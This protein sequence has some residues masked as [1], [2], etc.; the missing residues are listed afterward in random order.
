[1]EPGGEATGACPLHAAAK[2][3][4][5]DIVRLLLEA[6]ADPNK[7]EESTGYTPLHYA[8]QAGRITAVKELLAAGAHTDAC[9]KLTENTTMQKGSV[10]ELALAGFTAKDGNKRPD[11]YNDEQLKIIRALFDASLICDPRALT[12]SLNPDLPPDF[13]EQIGL[14]L[15]DHGADPLATFKGR[16]SL[17]N[18]GSDGLVIARRLLDAG[19]P[20]NAVA[21]DGSCALDQAVAGDHKPVADLLR[22]AGAQMVG[23][24]RMAPP[25]VLRRLVENGLKIPPTAF[26]DI[27]FTTSPLVDSYSRNDLYQV[28]SILKEAGADPALAL[29]RHAGHKLEPVRVL[30]G[31]GFD[32]NITNAEGETPLMLCSDSPALVPI[33]L[34]MGAKVDPVDKSGKNVLLHALNYGDNIV[35]I[36]ALLRAG[37]DP[38]TRDL[39][40]NSALTLAIKK[41]FFDL[42]RILANRGCR[43]EAKAL[44]T[45][46]DESG[47]TPLMRALLVPNIKPKTIK[48]LISLGSDVNAR[49]AEGKSPLHIIA[50][51]LGNI[52][53]IVQDL[54]N[55]KADINAR[56][57]EGITALMIVCETKNQAKRSYRISQLLTNGADPNIQDANGN[58]A[59]MHLANMV[60]DAANIEQLLDAGA[61][62]S[63]KNNNGETLLQIA[64][65]KNRE[66]IL[67]LLESHTK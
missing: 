61:K 9:V 58:T 7:P 41:D 62:T 37:A 49:N 33:L 66:N 63:L 8:V 4:R 64:K 34:S 22:S 10:L 21:E 60:D 29:L 13:R 5:A 32:P 11:F 55:A 16:T 24:V 46:A 39:E 38:K 50:A 31:V 48:E 3:G 52:S 17:I 19:V 27:C 56:T 6:G 54:I 18:H 45:V 51:Q 14:L 67:K 25:E 65:D 12:F 43:E 30:V 1:M 59:A 23:R 15:L 42:V 26:A 40:G 47:N 44:L 20:V 36:G 28:A 35:I 53:P 2:A 57:K